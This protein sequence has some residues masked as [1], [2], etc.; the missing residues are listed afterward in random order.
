MLYEIYRPGTDHEEIERPIEANSVGNALRAFLQVPADRGGYV[1]L[2]DA[3]QVGPVTML[4]VRY[5]VRDR[6]GMGY[7]PSSAVII[8]MLG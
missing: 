6:F 2:L 4:S 1:E 3:V 5:H 8:R 7:N